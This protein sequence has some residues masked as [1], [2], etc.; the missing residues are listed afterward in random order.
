MN[1]IQSKERV[2]QFGEVF[3]PDSIVNDM[4]DLVEG[5]LKKDITDEQYL[6]K[7]WLEPACGDGQF[8]IRILYR[9][10]EVISKLPEEKR[11][12]ALVKALTTIYGVDIQEDNVLKS[13]DRM[14]NIIKGLPV[15]TFDIKEPKVFDIQI[16]CG[17]T[18]T[19]EL[20]TVLSFILK[21]NIITGNTLTPE[22]LT[23]KEFRF[24][25]EDVEILHFTLSNLQFEVNR[26]PSVHY[27]NLGKISETA[28]ENE[29]DDY[30][31]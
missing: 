13:R 17:V 15:S 30:D 23:I 11:Q 9:K 28:Q 18:I 2:Q 31:F 29:D 5:E 10:L 25:G 4:I 7:T 16:D 20:E 14:M 22:N 19:P 8:L 21:E 1:G 6:E 26:E 27:M 24:D 3:T 12:L